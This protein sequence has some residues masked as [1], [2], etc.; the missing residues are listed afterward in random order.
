M[1]SPET[2]G[3][4]TVG[5]MGAAGT[6]G[7]VPSNGATGGAGAI[8]AIGGD[9]G[10]EPAEKKPLTTLADDGEVGIAVGRLGVETVGI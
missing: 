2:G 9:A 7:C 10:R 5:T 8:G 3:S 4:E 6:T 1:A